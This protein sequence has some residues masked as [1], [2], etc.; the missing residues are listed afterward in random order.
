M[1]ATQL[2]Q[3]FHSH[4][5]SNDMLAD[6]ARLFSE[7]YGVWGEGGFGKPGKRRLVVTEAVRVFRLFAPS[8][9]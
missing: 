2:F 7:H 6:A 5:V 4:E 3:A 8:S 1:V 9:C